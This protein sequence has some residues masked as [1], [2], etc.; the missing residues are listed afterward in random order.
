MVWIW[1]FSFPT[2]CKTSMSLCGPANVFCPNAGK[3]K[4]WG[5]CASHL[6]LYQWERN[7][8][9]FSANHTWT[10]WQTWH[11]CQQCLCWSACEFHTIVMENDFAKQLLCHN[12]NYFLRRFLR[13]WAK[14]SGKLIQPYGIPS[15][16]QASGMYECLHALLMPYVHFLVFGIRRYATCS[17]GS[18]WAVFFFFKENSILL[19][20]PA[21]FHKK[22]NKHIL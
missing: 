2:Y 4:G 10:E 11:S 1:I 13:T 15:T 20:F 3:R 16:T 8:G 7:W 9:S 12:L 17:K 22:A 19:L 6:R 21:K 14:S 5:L 18:R